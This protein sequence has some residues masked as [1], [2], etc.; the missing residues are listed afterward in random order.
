[1]NSPPP[2]RARSRYRQLKLLVTQQQAGR[3]DYR[4]YAKPI[5]GGWDE[6]QLIVSDSVDVGP[7]PLASTEDCVHALILILREQLLPGSIE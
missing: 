7:L 2:P 5:E 6:R 4:I 3:L 1:M